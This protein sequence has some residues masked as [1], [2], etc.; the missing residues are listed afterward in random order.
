MHVPF[1]FFLK[2]PVSKSIFNLSTLDLFFSYYISREVWSGGG[3][4]LEDY[5][6]VKWLLGCIT[7]A[8]GGGGCTEKNCN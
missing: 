8:G 1:L 4:A 6:S 5:G 3:E 7:E 2:F